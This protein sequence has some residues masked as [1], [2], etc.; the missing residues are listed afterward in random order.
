MA[1]PKQSLPINFSQGL[2]TKTDPFQ[3]SPGKFLSL[4]NIV[5]N[6]GGQLTKRSGYLQ[7]PSLSDTSNLYTTTFNDNLTAIGSSFNAFSAGP[8]AWVNKGPFQ[9]LKLATLPL[10]RSNTSQSQVDAAVAANGLIC[11]V[12]T[13]NIPAGP[14]ATVASFRYAIADSVTGQNVIPPTILQPTAGAITGSPRV[15]ILR[16]HFVVVFSV[17]ISGV[18]HLQYMAISTANPTITT[19]TVNISS[20]YTS[21]STVA[22]D[23]AVIS[24]ALY[25]AWNGNDVGGA[26]R[27]T[28]IDSTL[29]Q[30]NTV[31]F[32]GFKGNL[33]SVTADTS[34]GNPIVYTSFFDSGTNNGYT[35][36][37]NSQLLTILVPTQIISATSVTA[38]T[39]TAKSML[40]SVYYEVFNEYGYDSSLQTDYI[41]TVT[42]T[43][44]GTVGPTSVLVRSVGIASKAFLI[45]NTPYFL[46]IYV[47]VF[48][49]TYFLID[50]STG[51]P[52]AKLAYE[53]AIDSY[54]GVGIPNVT[55]TDNVAQ[56]PYFY[57]DLISAVN[58]TQGAAN[59]AGVYSQTGI[60]LVTFTIGT[61]D[62]VSGEI[63]A[64]LNL[65][66]GFL[67]GYD[68]YVAVENGF[69]LWPDSVETTTSGSGGFITAQ[70]YFYVA[71][72]EWSDNQGN[73][74]R[75]APSIPV[76]QITTGS[77]S[78][79]TINVPTLRLTYKTA[80]PAK[81]VIY[82]WST[83]QQTYFQVT[84][85]IS[86]LYNDPTIDYVTFVDTQAD[87]SIIGNNILYTTG[88]VIE[89]ISPP[90]LDTL[91]LYQS[92]L[93]LVDAEDKN[94]LWFSKQVIEQTPVEMSDLL[95]IFIPPTTGAQ[96]ST[97]PIT[98]LSVLDDKLVIFKRDA[99]Y[100][101]NGAGPDNTGANN[102]F[103]D[104]FFITATVGC[105][106]QHSI[107]FQP[108]GL[109]FQSDKGI[110]L[111]GRDLS[112]SYIGAPV[113]QYT[114]NAL[115]Q[116]AVNVPG[117][118]QVRFTLDSGLTLMYDYYYQQWGTF[119][120]VSAISSTLYQNLHT[121]I[122]SFG[123]VFQESPG[124]YLDGA[125]PVLMSFDSSW[126]NLAGLQGF[127]RAYFFY[128]LGTYISPHRLQLSIAYDYS[129]SPSQVTYIQPDN[130]NTPWGGEQ[131]WGS[132]E[133]WGGSLA[134]EQWRVFFQQGKCQAF[135]IQLKEIFDS[136]FGVPAGAGL[137]MSGLNIIVGAKRSFT[138][139]KPSRSVG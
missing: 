131:L 56:I 36:A 83:A 91:T 21:S 16:N 81:I 129:P 62:I 7:L 9:P 126:F 10:I 122:D 2:D 88:G 102:N 49:P 52:V 35:L 15:F 113:E 84:S 34:S 8:Q 118:N 25:L 108:G 137:T 106:N 109:M 39:S 107:V 64:N 61:S 65:S 11:T 128:L 41:K 85:I 90:A 54:Y 43:Q 18:N 50:A 13:D 72:T 73:V 77:T 98:A 123:R 74:F 99:V 32:P 55:V 60:N 80:N 3:V 6:K 37:V 46:A 135:Q 33:F 133:D 121:Y 100:Y 134:A 76:E 132:G 97:G 23:G 69:F 20:Q 114:Q 71:T 14:G 119:S 29:L 40:V 115:V 45:N 112:T 136:T 51:K 31:S 66:G 79:N 95:T 17:V 26:I 27:M 94:L 75:S 130:F 24:N 82:R 59:S 116:S 86:P 67:W 4:D 125:E 53:N 127:E 70:T 78:A 87:S 104:A 117:T 19:A 92:R 103:S 111:L 101:L 124:K 42:V 138:T 110:W 5:F 120:G 105:T 30:H 89:N 93:F 57:K 47:S 28:V 22:F 58:K 63:G 1:L 68:G 139:L 12:Y 44:T 38:I 96:G 48:Q